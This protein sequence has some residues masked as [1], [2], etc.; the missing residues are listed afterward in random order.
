M[1]AVEDLDGWLGIVGRLIF[2]GNHGWMMQKTLVSVAYPGRGMHDV[3][4]KFD[5]WGKRRMEATVVEWEGCACK[6]QS[7]KFLFAYLHSVRIENRIIQL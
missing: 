4:C 6:L 3:C 2:V 5:W 1:C 7:W